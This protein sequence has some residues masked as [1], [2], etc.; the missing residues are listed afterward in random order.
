MLSID[1]CWLAVNKLRGGGA[2]PPTSLCTNG[3]CYNKLQQVTTSYKSI[4]LQ[5][6]EENKWEN[7]QLQ[8]QSAH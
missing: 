2:I 6:K 8:E 5:N 1:S 3:A 7:Q 4:S